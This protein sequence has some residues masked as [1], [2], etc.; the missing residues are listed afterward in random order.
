MFKQSYYYRT[1][2]HQEVL[3]KVICCAV[4]LMLINYHTFHCHCIILQTLNTLVAMCCLMCSAAISR[5][6]CWAKATSWFWTS[7]FCCHS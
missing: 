5:S 1:V 2:T 3:L 4:N 7:W 6:L